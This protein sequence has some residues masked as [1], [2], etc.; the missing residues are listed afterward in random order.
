MT[1]IEPVTKEQASPQAQQLLDGVQKSI[2]LTPNLMTTLAHS[3]PALAAY[4]GFGQ[5]LST[6]SISAKEREQIALAVAGINSCEYCASAHTAVGSMLGVNKDE[7]AN[8]LAGDSED[9]R[10]AAILQFATSIVETR[11]W[12]ADADLEDARTAGLSE[13]EIVEIVATVSINIF[14]NYF[15]HIAATKVDFPIV[16][17]AAPTNA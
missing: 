12:V 1:R 6:A 11:G 2:G 10:T 4:L 16:E 13:A 17:V 15:N 14:T 5:A 7:L 8:N 9:D 3:G